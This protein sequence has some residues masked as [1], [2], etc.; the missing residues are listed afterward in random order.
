MP[1]PVK[2]HETKFE[3][4]H[5]S[6]QSDFERDLEG[7]TKVLSNKKKLT[8]AIM[9]RALNGFGAYRS[10]EFECSVVAEHACAVISSGMCETPAPGT[11]CSSAFE[12]EEAC[13]NSEFERSVDRSS[14]P[15]Q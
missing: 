3:S 12:Y 13:S 7:N 6:E 5:S 14:A 15:E 1:V 10:S 4:M 8:R 9:F 2:S 11:L